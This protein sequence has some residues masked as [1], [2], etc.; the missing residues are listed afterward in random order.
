MA[1][2]ILVLNQPK[3]YECNVNV[4][5]TPFWW[6]ITVDKL[7]RESIESVANSILKF[8][9]SAFN[10]ESKL[11]FTA[12]CA[13][14]W[15]MWSANKTVITCQEVPKGNFSAKAKLVLDRFTNYN[16]K[17]KFKLDI[18]DIMV[19]DVEPNLCPF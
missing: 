8:D 7:D 16:D 13:S 12:I 3:H 19:C 2:E 18:T 11:F 17:V 15:N 1:G 10:Q 14:K 6:I 4:F 5:R 9:K